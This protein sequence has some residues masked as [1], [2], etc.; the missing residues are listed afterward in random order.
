MKASILTTLGGFPTVAVAIFT[1][2]AVGAWTW[3]EDRPSHSCWAPLS[4]LPDAF[5]PPKHP[6]F[7]LVPLDSPEDSLTLATAG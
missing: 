5:H 4:V 7:A 1:P 2:R 6:E 3:P